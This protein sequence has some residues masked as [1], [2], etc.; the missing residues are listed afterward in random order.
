MYIGIVILIKFVSSTRVPSVSVK[1]FSNGAQFL[2]TT[3]VT[4]LSGC[5]LWGLLPATAAAIVFGTVIF[6]VT[7]IY[8][9]E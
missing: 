6:P 2:N 4:A 5:F 7:K 8:P 1:H 3:C 9:S